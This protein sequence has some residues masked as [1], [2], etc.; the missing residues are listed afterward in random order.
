MISS[1]SSSGSERLSMSVRL[2]S[3]IQKISRLVGCVATFNNQQESD[4]LG[5]LGSVSCSHP[6]HL[7]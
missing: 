1:A 5:R 4:W 7:V 3:L 6:K 2:L